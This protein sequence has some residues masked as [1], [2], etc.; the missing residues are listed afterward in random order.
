MQGS[1]LVR[2]CRIFGTQLSAITTPIAS[3]L[4]PCA[5]PDA[6]ICAP[7]AAKSTLNRLELSRPLRTRY[8]KISHDSAAIETLLVDLFLEAGGPFAKADHPRSRRHRRP[9]GILHRPF[10]VLLGAA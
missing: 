5:E 6:R 3:A 7:V 2:F 8:H 10:P 1:G 4:H 9:A